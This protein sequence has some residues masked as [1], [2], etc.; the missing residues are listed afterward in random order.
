MRTG[1]GVVASVGTVFDVFRPS[2]F[3]IEFPF[4]DPAPESVVLVERWDA[5]P[6]TAEVELAWP[7]VP[8][9]SEEPISM[10]LTEGTAVV[11]TELELGNFL[12]G[13]AWRL[14]GTDLG[15]V[16]LDADLLDEGGELFD[17]YA[18][19]SGSLD[20]DAGAGTIEFFWAPGFR[21]DQDEASTLRLTAR[22]ELGIPV[23]T[24]I[25][26]PLP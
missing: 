21:V 9:L 20:A 3:S 13:A 15:V 25:E 6:A 4:V 5:S 12:G 26:V 8:F 23:A 14:E 24:E 17:S 22:A 2:V 19:G 18:S 16:E 10:E 7:G 1:Q 11:I